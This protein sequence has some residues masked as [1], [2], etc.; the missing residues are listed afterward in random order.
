[1]NFVRG[2]HQ[3]HVAKFRHGRFLGLGSRFD[4]FVLFP[5]HIHNDAVVLVVGS[6]FAHYFAFCGQ[7][8]LPE[9]VFD[10]GT[11][12]LGVI[13]EGHQSRL[14]LVTIFTVALFAHLPFDRFQEGLC[15]CRRE[16]LLAFRTP[17]QARDGFEI[18]FDVR[19]TGRTVLAVHSVPPRQGKSE[20]VQKGAECGRWA[21]P[22]RPSEQQHG[23]PAA[24]RCQEI[25]PRLDAN[26]HRL[27]AV[28]YRLA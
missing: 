3:G 15:S 8:P 9:G 20:E 19:T 4:P 23:P 6:Y 17:N 10:S 1:M 26:S 27:S 21:Q 14:I 5:L 25:P 13:R 24:G 12:F 22:A 11:F 7:P 16:K 28:N 2:L 18:Q